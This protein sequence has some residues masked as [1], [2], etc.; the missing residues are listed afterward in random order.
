MMYRYSSQGAQF[1]RIPG[2]LGISVTLVGA[3]LVPDWGYRWLLVL[4]LNA[5]IGS[6]L[7]RRIA[8]A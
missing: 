1:G 4:L 8:P 5:P 7:E 3:L 2:G 6:W